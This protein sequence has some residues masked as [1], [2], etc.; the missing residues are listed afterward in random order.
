MRQDLQI[1]RYTQT[2]SELQEQVIQTSKDI[3]DHYLEYQREVINS[4]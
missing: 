2:V 4:V 3:A 1:P